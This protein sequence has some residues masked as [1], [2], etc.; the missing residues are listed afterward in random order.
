MT[1]DDVI[2]ENTK[3]SFANSVEIQAKPEKK[4]QPKKAKKQGR[5]FSLYLWDLLIKTI[6][7]SLLLGADFLIFAGAGSYDMFGNSILLNTEVWCILLGIVIFSF[8]L[9]YILSFFDFLQN[10]AISAIMFYLTLAFF[11]QYAAF[12]EG[13]ILSS[14]AANY[15]SQDLGIL[16]SNVSHIVIAVGLSILLFVFLTF[17][18]RT[19]NFVLLVL[20]LL[21]NIS[22]VYVQ[23]V[24]PREHRKFE[25]TKEEVVM[26]HANPKKQFIYIGMPNMVSYAYLSELKSQFPKNSPDVKEIDK[27][28]DIMLG[29]YADNDFMLYPQ[30]Y[31]EKEDAAQNFAKV[32][33]ANNNKPEKE[34]LLQKIYPE[35]L[36]HFNYL[37]NKST[38][39]K[40]SKIYDT[41]LKSKFSINAYQNDGIELCKINNDYAV[42]YCVEKNSLPIDFDNMK[43]STWDKTSML[44]AQWLQSTGLFDNLSYIYKGLH[45]FMNVDD[46]PLVG[47]SLADA[48]IKNS[49]DVLDL[50]KQDLQKADGHTAYF[51][52]LN[53]PGQGFI[54]DE[55]CHIRPMSEWQTN[56]NYAWSKDINTSQKRQAYLKQ[57]QCIYGSL[58]KFINELKANKLDKETVIVLQ[59]L[60]GMNGMFA[61]NEDEVPAN[62]FMNQK[63]VDTA[64]KDPL[65]KG[66]KLKNE[67]CTTSEVL[68]QYLYRKEKCQEELNINIADKEKQAFLE[69]RHQFSISEDEVKKAQDSFAKWYQTW[70]AQQPKNVAKALEKSSEKQVKAEKTMP[71]STEKDK[72]TEDVKEKTEE[73]ATEA[74]DK[75]EKAVKEEA[76]KDVVGEEATKEV[77]KTKVMDKPLNEEPEQATQP[78]N[79]NASEEKAGGNKE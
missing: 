43:I 34:Y 60:S 78:L 61:P 39:L 50:L 25:Y 17:A 26:A 48:D 4:E 29:F 62:K 5:S 68:E 12:D 38:Y 67:V 11:H 24:D 71:A 35:S 31:T 40:E 37:N 53:M 66:F 13:S 44:A 45:P 21:L 51:V 59:G 58:Q 56:Q 52:D 42:S 18:T 19:K 20:L 69:K 14:M 9:M 63:F 28:Q 57:V 6:I 79:A 77:G 7:T 3:E 15:I 54:Y 70:E 41:F 47:K 73:K 2:I 75:E 23:K 27:T 36:W 1:M 55:Y 65:K 30:A 22:I 64:I 72:K 76:P 8:V 74:Q 10:L 32:L 46:M 49:L 33:N 16:L